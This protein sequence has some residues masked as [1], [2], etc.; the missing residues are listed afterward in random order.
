MKILSSCLKLR[1]TT[2]FLILLVAAATIAQQPKPA[3][4]PARLRPLIGEYVHDNQTVIVLENDG[5]LYAL[6]KGTSDKREITPAVFSHNQ[7]TLDNI[8]YKRQPLGPEPGANQLKVTPLR[9]VPDLIKEALAAQPPQ[10]TGDFLPTDLVELTKLD[11]TIRLDIRYATTNNLFGTVFY[12]QPRA[13]LQ[14]AP[15]EALVRVSQKL[16]PLGYGLLVHDGYRPWYV[17]KV[18][19]EATPDDKKIFVADP[20]KGS[21]HNRGAAV[22]LSLYD[23]KTGKPIEMVSTYDETTDRAHPDYPGGTSLQRWHRDL[24]RSAMEAEGFTVYEAEWW[25]FD[26]KDWQRYHIG[27]QRFETIQPQRSKKK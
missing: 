18:F 25:H 26:Y 8:I 27:N 17:T 22:D 19:W 10:E 6:V 1:L 7:L 3:P 20:S 21:R 16:K 11:P 9:P 23:L 4:A 2:G 5:K 15:A 13:F 12:S 14:R 24:L